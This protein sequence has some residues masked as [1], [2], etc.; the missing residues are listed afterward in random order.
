MKFIIDSKGALLTVRVRVGDGPVHKV[1]YSTTGRRF[2]VD[3]VVIDFKYD[4]ENGAWFVD[5]EYDLTVSGTVLFKNGKL[6]DFKLA[7]SPERVRG[8][9]VPFALTEEWAWLSDLVDR[10]RPSGDLIAANV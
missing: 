9:K 6:G 2:K 4:P 10:V 3:Y 7:M 8:P 1:A 5:S